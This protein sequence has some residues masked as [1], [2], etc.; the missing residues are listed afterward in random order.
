M[1]AYVNEV[2]LWHS[3]AHDEPISAGF[4]SDLRRKLTNAYA[5]RS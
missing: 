1:R 3:I 2:G 4:I 5:H